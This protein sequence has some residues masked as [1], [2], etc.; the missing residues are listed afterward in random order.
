MADQQDI[1]QQFISIPARDGY[2]LGTTHFR[3]AS[4]VSQSQLPV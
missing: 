1:Q 4:V 3:I 2:E